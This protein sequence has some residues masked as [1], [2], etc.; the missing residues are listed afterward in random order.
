MRSTENQQ[1]GELAYAAR[2]LARLASSLQR[3]AFTLRIIKLWPY[4][5]DKAYIKPSL[6]HGILF[7]II[8]AA[9]NVDEST[10]GCEMPREIASPE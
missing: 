8:I 4:N 10:E 2:R 1:C 9:G 5:G 6:R 7:S 3:V